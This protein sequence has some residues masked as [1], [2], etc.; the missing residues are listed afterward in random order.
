MWFG[1]MAKG[2]C[3]GQ[4]FVEFALILPILTILLVGVTE[5]GF[6]FYAY[7]QVS[8]AAREGARAGSRY[9][10]DSDGTM[11]QN[12]SM[13]GWGSDFTGIHPSFDY[14]WQPGRTWVSDAVVKSL[15]SLP[16]TTSAFDPGQ[17]SVGGGTADLVVTYPNPSGQQNRWGESISV[18]VTYHYVM[19]F[20]FS[21]LL[22]VTDTVNLVSKTT[23]QIEGY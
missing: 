4:S 9:I 11:E 23:M 19:P 10:Y 17:Y 1:R 3:K 6:I 13:R 16:I 5:L 20:A 7:V 18:E 8:N 22:P 12:D 15:G 2:R 14:T 21:S